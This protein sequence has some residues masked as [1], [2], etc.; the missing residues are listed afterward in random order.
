[1]AQP[2]EIY[3]PKVPGYIGRSTSTFPS[4][5]G[6]GEGMVPKKILAFT[7]VS[8]PGISVSKFKGSG[9]FSR[10]NFTLDSIIVCSA[11]SSGFNGGGLIV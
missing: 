7:P 3:Q 9:Q 1:M 10:S 4:T 2:G 8:D 11:I 5:R 6:V